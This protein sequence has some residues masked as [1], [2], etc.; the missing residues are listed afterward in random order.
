MTL[1]D[2]ANAETAPSVEDVVKAIASDV[3]AIAATHGQ[4]SLAT[5]GK[6][7][8][9]HTKRLLRRA[10]ALA[11]NGDALADYLIAFDK[12]TSATMKMTGY[13]DDHA[14]EIDTQID[15]MI[16]AHDTAVE[17]FADEATALRNM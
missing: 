8:D 14:A 12:A 10:C 16:N 17:A 7:T 6:T 1:V 13:A 15:A 4:A 2:L 5:G 9:E 11:H 3:Q